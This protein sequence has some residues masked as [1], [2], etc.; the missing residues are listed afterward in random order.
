VIVAVL[1]ADLLFPGARSLKDKR[2]LLRGALDRVRAAFPVS[3][4]E[5]GH[6]DLLQRGSVGVALVTTD[7]VMARS[8]LERIAEGFDRGGEVEVAS[9]RL[10]LIPFGEEVAR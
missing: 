6:H 3:A 5:V 10:E 8:M 4:A 9:H 2:S 7:P 1:T